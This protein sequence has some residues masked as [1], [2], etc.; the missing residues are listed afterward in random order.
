[1]FGGERLATT[2]HA[3]RPW[4][5]HE[6][7]RDFR[8]LDVWALPTPGGPDD[9]DALVKLWGTFD[10]SHTS[11]VVRALFATRWSI[12]RLFG[13]DTPEAGLGGRVHAL[14]DR[15]PADLRSSTT[16]FVNSHGQFEP[17]YIADDEFAMEIANQTVHGVLHVGWVADA[18]GTHR[19]QMAVLVR[20]NGL[21]GR[22]YLAAIAPFRHLIVYPLMLR[23][24]GRLW[25]D[26][27]ERQDISESEHP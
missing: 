14:R 26:R 22:G 2:E 18:T 27:Q 16:C 17:L 6:L 20:P 24:I 3:S 25:R 12:G 23:D 5:I 9:F 8:V 11:L 13:L 21:M 15:L 7:A 1:M 19:G 4:R 10:P